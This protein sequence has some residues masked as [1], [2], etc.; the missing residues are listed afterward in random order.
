[1]QIPKDL[2]QKIINL[3]DL[4]Q[5][6]HAVKGKELK[7]DDP[8]AI[9]GRTPRGE[10]IRPDVSPQAKEKNVEPT[11]VIPS[12]EKPYGLKHLG[13]KR[14]YGQVVH[15]FGIP[16][17]DKHYELTVNKMSPKLE[18]TSKLVDSGTGGTVTRSPRIHGNIR[19]AAAEIVNHFNTKRW[20]S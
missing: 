15:M 5:A 8:H 6:I 18:Y 12:D 16:G 13:I 3:R 2:L 20:S 19:D 14:S 4:R 17:H 10:P 1:M 7:K 11:K 9:Y